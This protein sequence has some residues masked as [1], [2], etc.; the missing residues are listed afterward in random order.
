MAGGEGAHFQRT[1]T[2]PGR[3]VNVVTDDGSSHIVL[4]IEKRETKGA[5][6]AQCAKKFEIRGLNQEWPDRTTLETVE[7]AAHLLPAKPARA[8]RAPFL[9][10]FNAPLH[11]SLIQ[12]TLIS[13]AQA[14]PPP[15]PRSRP[16]HT[17]LP[18]HCS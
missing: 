2:S 4:P 7:R 17:H 12:S 6:A 9:R 5:A 18:L 1:V 14:S 8:G 3:R 11:S 13:P 15:L 10:P 16:S